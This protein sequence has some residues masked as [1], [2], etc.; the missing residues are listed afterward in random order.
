MT[1][2]SPKQY[3]VRGVTGALDKAIRARAKR[4]QVSVNRL[5]LAEL[6]KSFLGGE[7]KADFSKYVGVLEPD[8]EFDKILKDQRQIHWEDWK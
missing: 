6:E 5:L 4:D 1:K 8:P 7:Q 2:T 3:T